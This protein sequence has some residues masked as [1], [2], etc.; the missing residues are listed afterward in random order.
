MTRV[1]ERAPSKSARKREHLELQALG[2]KLIGLPLADLEA[3]ELDPSLLDAVVAAQSIRSRGALRRQRQLIGKLMRHAD[4]QRIA[5]AL[6]A[7]GRV[8]RADTA[9]LHAA[10]HWRERLCTE[11]GAAPREPARDSGRDTSA[12]E[13]VLHELE[14]AADDLAR[15]RVRRRLFREVHALLRDV[16]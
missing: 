6:E 3:M 4:A 16:A 1:N 2:E 15:R 12:L 10:E 9:L 14:R 13:P 7:R 8:A 11:G 5:A